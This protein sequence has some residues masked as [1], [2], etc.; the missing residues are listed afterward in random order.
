MLHFLNTAFLKN[1]KKKELHEYIVI[2]C[3]LIFVFFLSSA[4]FFTNSM[5]WKLKSGISSE[6]QEVCL[7]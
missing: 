1:N 6:A 7:A 2:F 3:L 4:D 5:F